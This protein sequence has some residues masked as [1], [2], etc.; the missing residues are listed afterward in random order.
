VPIGT[1]VDVSWRQEYVFLLDSSQDA[2]AG[3]EEE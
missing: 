3:L 2:G 1:H